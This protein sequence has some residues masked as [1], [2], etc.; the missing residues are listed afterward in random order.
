MPL[1]Y[2]SISNQSTDPGL[3]VIMTIEE[4]CKN[5]KKK[6]KVWGEVKKVIS[7]Y[8]HDSYTRA[9]MIF[10]GFGDWEPDLR[11]SNWVCGSGL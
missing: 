3:D 8:L 10:G 7:Y 6:K 9:F 2:T 11:D 4:A 1:W 5:T